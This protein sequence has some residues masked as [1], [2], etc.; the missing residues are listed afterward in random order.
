MKTS[1]KISIFIIILIV[2]AAIAVPLIYIFVIKKSRS[3]VASGASGSS[4]VSGSNVSNV[5]SIVGGSSGSNVVS[6][7]SGSNVVSGS[8]GSNVASDELLKIQKTVNAIPRTPLYSAWSESMSDT[9]ASKSQTCGD[10]IL[11]NPSTVPVP[12]VGYILTEA[13]P[14]YNGQPTTLPLY[15]SWSKSRNDNCTGTIEHCGGGGNVPLY[16][17]GTQLGHV[18]ADNV[19]TSSDKTSPLFGSWGG[20]R[21]DACL[22]TTQ[23]C[24]GGVNK[25][26]YTPGTPISGYIFNNLTD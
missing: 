25:D 17:S 11:Y 5:S 16:T 8:S 9:C 1:R 23:N 7:S 22:D 4:I 3:S 26:L 19:Y 12:L 15:L 2:I 18:M 21:L 13:G 24:G 10:P 14:T 20:S 6:G